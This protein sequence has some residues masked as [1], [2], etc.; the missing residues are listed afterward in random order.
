MTGLR[1]HVCVSSPIQLGDAKISNI[2]F[3]LATI[4]VAIIRLKLYFISSKT[5]SQWLVCLCHSLIRPLVHVGTVCIYLTNCILYVWEQVW[6]QYLQRHQLSNSTPS[7]SI[8]QTR[9]SH[10]YVCEDRFILVEQNSQP[11]HLPWCSRA[12]LI[13]LRN[14]SIWLLACAH[15]NTDN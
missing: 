13:L 5:I 6:S 8:Y 11:V 15:M 4:P 2:Y 7:R 3:S 9:I 10:V 14:F 12:D 1:K